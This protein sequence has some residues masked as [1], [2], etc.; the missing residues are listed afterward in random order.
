MIGR[1]DNKLVGIV[2]LGDLS[3]SDEGEAASVALDGI[4][5]PGGEHNQSRDS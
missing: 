4:T 3:R 5:D 1:E 2:S